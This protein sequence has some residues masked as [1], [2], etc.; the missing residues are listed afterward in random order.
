[1]PAGEVERIGLFAERIYQ[2]VKDR[3]SALSANRRRSTTFDE[4]ALV[5]A[6]H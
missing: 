4:N 6:G 5:L 3:L 2:V 1:M